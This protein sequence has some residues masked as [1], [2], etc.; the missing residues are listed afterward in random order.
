MR[1]A[2]AAIQI[3][4]PILIAVMIVVIVPVPEDLLHLKGWGRSGWADAG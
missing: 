4:V 1:I 2:A 3:L